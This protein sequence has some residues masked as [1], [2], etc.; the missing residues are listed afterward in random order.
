MYSLLARIGAAVPETRFFLFSDELNETDADLLRQT[1]SNV[2]K[3]FTLVLR[4][5]DAAMFAGFPPLNGSWA[6]Y[7]RLAVPKILDVERFLYVDADTLSGVDV[8]ELG[9]LDMGQFPAGWVPEATLAGAVDRGVAEQL[10]NR[11]D[12]F[13][14]NAGV[15][16]VNVAEWR[17]Q[18]I[19]D[20]AMEYLKQNHPAFWDQSALNVVLQGNA[21]RLEDKFNCIANMRKNWPVLIRPDGKTG[22]LVH[23]LDYPKPWDWLG[24]LVHPQYALWRAVLDKTAMKDFR[25]WQATPAR[26]FPKTRKGWTGYKKAFKDRLLFTG[27][28][29]GWLKHVKGVS[30]LMK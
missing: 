2:G 18:K 20:L 24:E 23:F 6:T 13:Y 28:S 11:P 12:A 1:L 22:K 16:L 29:K 25:S 14:F 8:S 19:T 10:G 3:R 21:V 26:K 15:M 17:R 5:V 9:R 7:Y 30:M 4:L 27:Y